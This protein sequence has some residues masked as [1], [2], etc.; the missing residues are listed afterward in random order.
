MSEEQTPALTELS[1]LIEQRNAID[2]HIA[3]MLDRPA[4]PGG[5]GEWIAER[6][7][8]IELETAAN[9]AGYDGRF[10]KGAISGKTVNVKAYGKNERVLD[11]NPNAPL[12]YYLVFTGPAGGAGSSRGSV[13]PFCIDK[14]FLFDAHT[15]HADLEERR[16]RI[17][18]ATSVR[19]AQWEAAEIFPSP[20]NA[21]LRVS[22]LQRRQL[23]LF[24]PDARP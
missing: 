2:V 9:T 16:V 24:K 6:I 18:V 21:T 13:R 14:V 7:F 17:G 10:T 5:M 1:V 15:L 12:D 3:R 4:S 19:T 8:D 22:D 23:E 11:I 20:N